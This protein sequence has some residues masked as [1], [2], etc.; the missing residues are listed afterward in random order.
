VTV[1]S[2]CTVHAQIARGG[3]DLRCADG[4]GWLNEPNEWSLEGDIL[5]AVTEFQTD[6]WR[7]TFYGWVTENGHFYHQ[8]VTG[9]F[10]AEVVVSATHTRRSSTRPA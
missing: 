1:R 4:D 9:D 2:V 5:R 10:T 3:Y 7:K 8:P 6:F